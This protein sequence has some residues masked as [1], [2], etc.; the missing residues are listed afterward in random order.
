MAFNCLDVER[1]ERF[2]RGK[3]SEEDRDYIR[4]IFCNKSNEKELEHIARKIWYELI[5][6]DDFKDK[7]FE[8]ILYR[9]HYE[10]NT[11]EQISKSRKTLTNLVK[12]SARVAAIIILPILI[13]SGIHFYKNAQ[14][15][16]EITWVEVNAPAWTRVQFS[17]PDG[18][19]GWLNGSSDIKYYS[20][21]TKERK[22]ILDGEAFFN[23]KTDP[24]IPF[25]VSTNEI[26]V[27]AKGT[28]FNIASYGNEKN[29]EVVLEEGELLV[30]NKE[31]TSS[32]T[33]SQN[34]LVVY[35]K[36]ANYL[37]KEL[38]DPQIYVAWTEGKLV[39]RNDPID[40]I[41][42]RLGRW[43]NV[44]VEIS[45]NNFEDVRLRATF[46]DENLEEVLYFLKRALPVDYKIIKGKFRA[47][48]EIY[49][50]KKIMITMRK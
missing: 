26:N 40:V 37:S 8:H 28:K 50:K 34:D 47:D 30:G 4:R 9:I 10:I 27:T 46:V 31:M 18:S 33:M 1:L 20:N 14:K 44:D 2:F 25:V 49:T 35:D 12:W 41:A 39:F 6:E 45:G 15:G 17:L 29:V 24:E 5:K 36:S 42:R 11:I 7:S 22:V 48:D 23:V 32:Y 43:Y 13:Y 38:V 3:F 19:T 21:F 16:N